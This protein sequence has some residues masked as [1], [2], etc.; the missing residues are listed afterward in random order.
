[1]SKKLV[2][3][4]NLKTYFYTEAGTAKAVDDVSFDIYSGEVLGIVGES[5]SG[6]SV[7]SLSI[8]RLIPNPPGKIVDGEILYNK[9]LK[10]DDDRILGQKI[11][12]LHKGSQ[13]K[14]NNKVVWN[15]KNISG[16]RVASGTYFIHI[17]NEN[18]FF[19]ALFRS[20]IICVL[21]YSIASTK[22]L[23]FYLISSITGSNDN[24]I[25]SST[26]VEE[27]PSSINDLNEPID[28]VYY[29]PIPNEELLTNKEFEFN[30]I[31]SKSDFLNTEF[32][33][34]I[35][36]I[37]PLT[38]T[39]INIDNDGQIINKIINPG[40][41]ISLVVDSVIKFDIWSSSHVDCKLNDID[42]NTLFG[43]EEQSIRGSFEAKDQRLYYQ[44]HSQLQY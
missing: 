5:G 12:Q 42:L 9:T 11:K 24:S 34:Y 13:F 36:T 35:F 18:K 41:Y 2:Q 6:K 20:I 19:R 15:G 32:P 10:I 26:A 21:I 44:I 22:A 16:H 43:R 8:N 1:M 33:P 27:Q 14:G 7:T 38:Q 4:K 28:E 23:V 30:L 17:Q 31:S 40:E 25:D 29:S 37:K 39:K 3:I